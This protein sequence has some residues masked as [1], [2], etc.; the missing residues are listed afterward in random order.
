MAV[1]YIK[2]FLL[3]FFIYS[4]SIFSIFSSV[5]SDSTDNTTV[6]HRKY[7]YI[8]DEGRHSYKQIMSLNPYHIDEDH[9]TKYMMAAHGEPSSVNLSGDFPTAFTQGK[10]GSCTAVSLISLLIYDMKKSG[11]EN[12]EM[13]SVLYL[14]Y[15]A[16]FLVDSENYDFGVSLSDCILAIQ[17]FGVCKESLWPYEIEKFA[18]KPPKEACVDALLYKDQLNLK[19]IKKVSQDLNVM[20]TMLNRG[21]PFACGI[22]I[23]ESFDSKGV[24]NTGIV[25]MPQNNEAS[26][27]SHA[28]VFVGYNDN[29]KGGCFL[30]MNSWGPNWGTNFEGDHNKERGY[31]WLPY[32]YATNSKLAYDFWSINNIIK[33]DHEPVQSSSCFCSLF[34]KL[35]KRKQ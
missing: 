31:F 1:Q 5:G 13:Q 35:I 20:K 7:S 16:R 33:M 25:P 21:C 27:G 18:I 15:W 10:L 34:K 9:V 22:K 4:I 26:K 24:E 28:V 8:P 19:R 17:K 2:K 14:Y 29:F 30:V 32:K 11:C 3:L 12:V 6:A 23:Y